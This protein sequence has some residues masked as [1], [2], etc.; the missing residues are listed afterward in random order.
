M[1]RIRVN[2]AGELVV[3]A[4]DRSPP[5]G[6]RFWIFAGFPNDPVEP[7]PYGGTRGVVLEVTAAGLFAVAM[8]L[9]GA[10][11]LFNC[12][13][14]FACEDQSGAED[15]ALAWIA[16]REIQPDLFA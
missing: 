14:L 8:E 1:T 9:D 16:A 3:L 6:W 2:L 12:H 5:L 7:R 4:V 11:R 13:E 10:A 15:F